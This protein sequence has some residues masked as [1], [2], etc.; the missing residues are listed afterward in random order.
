[1]VQSLRDLQSQ[2][3][4]LVDSGGPTSN[5]ARRDAV[6]I[7]DAIAGVQGRVT[8]ERDET[9]YQQSIQ[10]YRASANDKAA[11]DASRSD[12]QSIMRGGGHRAADAQK[13]VDDI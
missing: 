9:A 3:Q 13:I 11:L 4:A 6:S 1:A 7:P 2:F 8:Y 5:D 10:R 12:F